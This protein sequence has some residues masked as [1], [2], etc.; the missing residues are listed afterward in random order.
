MS[1]LANS[2]YANGSYGIDLNND[3]ATANDFGDPDI[4]GNN[5]QNFPVLVSAAITGISTVAISGTLNSTSSS[6]FRVEFFSN[7]VCDPSGYGEGES[8]LGFVT[9]TTDG[10][11]N[12]SFTESISASVSLGHSVTATAT[13]TQGNTSEFSACVQ[14][15]LAEGIP[16]VNGIGLLVAAGL[17]GALFVWALRRRS[18]VDA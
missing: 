8:F 9:S 6:D 5:A 12:A 2:I 17:F 4:G 16:S 10:T 7:T 18:V 3:G 13:D 1:I 14:V 15:V 11:G